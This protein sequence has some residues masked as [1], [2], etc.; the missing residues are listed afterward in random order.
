MIWISGGVDQLQVL[1][2]EEV[3]ADS[4]MK[5]SAISLPEVCSARITACSPV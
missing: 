2:E 3:V 1:E 5:E 4:G